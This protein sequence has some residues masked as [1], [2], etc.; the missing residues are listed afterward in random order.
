MKYPFINVYEDD[1]WIS[2]DNITQ[3]IIRLNTF[4]D[5]CIQ[6]LL[7]RLEKK[8]KIGLQEIEFLG[9]EI[10]GKVVKIQPHILEKI[11]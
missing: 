8:A 2:S 6:H 11:S 1:I 10:D 5:L 9:M 7:A 4:A 3:H